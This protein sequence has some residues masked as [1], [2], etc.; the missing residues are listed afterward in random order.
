MDALN[1]EQGSEAWIKL[2]L[3]KV[4]ASRISD[5]MART[6]S[7]WSA[8]RDAYAA[9]LICE[10]L[11]GQR[12]EKFKS[13]SMERGNEVED[14]ARAAYAFRFDVDPVPVGF[15]EHPTIAMAGCS[16]DRLIAEDG[17]LEIKSPDSHTHLATLLGASIPRAYLLQMQWQL[18][19]CQ[20]QWV[21]FVSFDP[22]FPEHMNLSIKR[23]HRDDAMI[24]EM[25]AAVVD[26]L[27]ELDRQLKELTT[28]F[29]PKPDFEP[30]AALEPLPDHLAV[31]L[32]P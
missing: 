19:C 13:K 30:V 17:L 1:V 22:R 3:G 7:G 6:K 8:S 21:D 15:V 14:D 4:T 12:Y 20:R 11:S 26:F 2:R 27:L 24:R 28:R 25:E 18:C 23:V 9:E 32:M 16:P 29:Q 31:G 5:L 10:R